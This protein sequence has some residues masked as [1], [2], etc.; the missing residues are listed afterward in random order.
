MYVFLSLDTEIHREINI[1][2]TEKPPVTRN[3]NADIMDLS[4]LL[5]PSGTCVCKGYYWMYKIL[6]EQF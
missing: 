3:S 4:F 6:F 5:C 2:D 1:L